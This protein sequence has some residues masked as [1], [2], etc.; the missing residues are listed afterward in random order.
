MMLG[1][2]MD[3]ED[4]SDRLTG[5]ITNGTFNNDAP[6]VSS[7][8]ITVDGRRYKKS[9]QFVNKPAWQRFIILFAGPLFNFI[10][11]FV[12]ALIITA[13]YGYDRPRVA[14]VTDGMP[15]A[16]AGLEEGDLITG[17]GVFGNEISEDT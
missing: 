11:A 6:V 17:I 7:D 1:E 4:G 13:H 10:L 9:E 2:E 8:T 16:E 3:E 5:D 15:A 14:L 12:F